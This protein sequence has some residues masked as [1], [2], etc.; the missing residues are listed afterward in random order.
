MAFAARRTLLVSLLALSLTSLASAQTL[1]RVQ[2]APAA[3]SVACG[4]DCGPDSVTQNRPDAQSLSSIACV[5]ATAPTVTS[6]PAGGA[7]LAENPT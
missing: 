4:R 2:R 6:T 1:A 7:L 3:P 5:L